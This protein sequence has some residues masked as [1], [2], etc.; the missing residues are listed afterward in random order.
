MMTS[1]VM[2]DSRT[3]SADKYWTM[4]AALNNRYAHDHGHSFFWFTSR[5]NSSLDGTGA[6]PIGKTHPTC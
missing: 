1:V 6:N 3:L 2:W 5:T 4:A